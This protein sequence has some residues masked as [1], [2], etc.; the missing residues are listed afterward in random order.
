MADHPCHQLAE[1][2]VTPFPIG[3]PGVSVKLKPN[4]HDSHVLAAVYDGNPDGPYIP[5][6][7]SPIPLKRNPGGVNF[8]LNDPPFFISEADFAYNQDKDSPGLPGK[9]RFGYLHHFASF[10]VEHLP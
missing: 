10:P 2:R 4:R 3:A 1:R 7:N 5:G 8:R 9:V 6:V